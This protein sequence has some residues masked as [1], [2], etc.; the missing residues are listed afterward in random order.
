MFSCI[1]L[2]YLY[3]LSPHFLEYFYTRRQVGLNRKDWKRSFGWQDFFINI[4]MTMKIYF[5]Q[6]FLCLQDFEAEIQ[7]SQN[8]FLVSLK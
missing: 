7:F 8:F 2:L 4:H 1:F 5:A 6:Y 3:L